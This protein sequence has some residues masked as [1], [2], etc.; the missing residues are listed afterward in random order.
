RAEKNDGGDKE[1]RRTNAPSFERRSVR[2]QAA[3][4]NQCGYSDQQPAEQPRC[5]SRTE[6]KAAHARKIAPR[7]ERKQPDQSKGNAAPE[8]LRIFNQPASLRPPRLN[9]ALGHQPSP[10]A[11][12]S[13]IFPRRSSP[14]LRHLSSWS[15]AGTKRNNDRVSDQSGTAQ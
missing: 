11:C 9:D 6:G 5:S 15:P 2:D 4:S 14:N 1:D 3:D 8:I 12:S 10:N 7:P 13:T